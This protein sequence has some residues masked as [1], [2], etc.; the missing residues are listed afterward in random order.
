VSRWRRQL[1]RRHRR[2]RALLAN[3]VSTLESLRLITLL[4]DPGQERREKAAKRADRIHRTATMALTYGACMITK[5]PVPATLMS[6]LT[7]TLMRDML[8]IV[9]DS[10][11]GP[12][13]PLKDRSR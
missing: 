9:L 12:P 10:I 4:A 1:V 2:A 6:L 3:R 5:T 8:D 11:P 13:P 7:E